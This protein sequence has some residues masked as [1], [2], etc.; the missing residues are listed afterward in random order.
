MHLTFNLRLSVPKS[1][2]EI[3]KFVYT[4]YPNTVL[5]TF[6]KEVKTLIYKDLQL[7]WRQRYAFNGIVLYLVSTVFICYLSFNAKQ[8]Q[9]SIPVWNALFWIILLFTAVN[10]MAKSFIQEPEERQIYYYILVSPQAIIISKIIYNTLLMWLM[11]AIGFGVYALILGNPVQDTSLFIS[12]IILGG[13]GFAS[14]L[15]MIAGIASKSGNN[16]TL[17][18]VL[19]FPVI[20]PLLLLLIKISK[21]ALDGLSLTASY[22][23][24]LSIGSINAIVLVLSFILFPYLWRS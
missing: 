8:N 20:L 18:A 13:L 22:D 21:N 1:K 14:V 7:E 19:S 5:K 6:F 24:L 10:A 2:I 23:E 12:N 15:T 4:K 9:L 17:M 11:S 16:T 3:L